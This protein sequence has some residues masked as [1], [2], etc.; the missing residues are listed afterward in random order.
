MTDD[1]TALLR[2]L[3][4]GPATRVV[5]YGRPRSRSLG[6]PLGGAADRAALALGNALVGNPPDA[7][8]LEIS[9]AGPTL[10]A[11]VE[12]GCVLSG[13]P[14]DLATNRRHLHPGKTFTL[15]AGE[16]LRIGGSGEGVRAYLCVRGG[17]QTARILGSCSGLGPLKAD[18]ELPCAPSRV[19]AHFLR[20]P[21]V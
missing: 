10:E 7:A 11:T 4:A 1:A 8:A 16:V 5:D 17:L 14:F 18:D 21:P 19:A 12:L 2:V 3:A 13:A 6:V 20:L 15:D 9:L